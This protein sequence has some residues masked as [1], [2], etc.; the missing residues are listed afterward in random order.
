LID[1]LT[2]G[3][4]GDIF[5]LILV[6]N[7]KNFEKVSASCK[8]INKTWGI[9]FLVASQDG[10]S[11]SLLWK[12]PKEKVFN[13]TWRLLTAAKDDH[14]FWLTSFHHLIGKKSI[15]FYRYLINSH[16]V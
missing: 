1:C 2:A 14:S 10:Y 3:E 9:L 15:F 13:S 4:F 6:S 5:W 7:A 8:E 11:C 12:Y 16:N